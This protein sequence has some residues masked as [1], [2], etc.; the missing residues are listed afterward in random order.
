MIYISSM[1]NIDKFDTRNGE[2]EA[3]AYVL[4]SLLFNVF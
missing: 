4:L 3:K 1:M 2:V